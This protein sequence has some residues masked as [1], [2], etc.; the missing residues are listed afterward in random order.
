MNVLKDGVVA[1]R[2]HVMVADIDGLDA[3]DGPDR[4]VTTRHITAGFDPAKTLRA[5]S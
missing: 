3:V 4:D 2:Y 5:E 1:R